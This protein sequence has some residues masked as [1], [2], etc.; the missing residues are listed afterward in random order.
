[1]SERIPDSPDTGREI[2]SM[3]VERRDDDLSAC[4]DALS[5]SRAPWRQR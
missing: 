2:V 1:M 3:P 4:T 5:G